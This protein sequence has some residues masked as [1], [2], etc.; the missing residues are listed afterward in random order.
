[1]SIRATTKKQKQQKY[2][3]PTATGQAQQMWRLV[4]RLF[5]PPAE[6]AAMSM[7]TKKARRRWAVAPAVATSTTQPPAGRLLRECL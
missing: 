3:K 7:T 2:W 5:C 6:A 4:D 1:M